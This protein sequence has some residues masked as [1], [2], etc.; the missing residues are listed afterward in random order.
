M[1][2]D[3]RLRVGSFYPPG[4]PFGFG[5]IVFGVG[6]ITGPIIGA[7]FMESINLNGFFVFLII[8]N[9]L[10]ATFGIYRSRVRETVDNPESSFTPLPQ[11]ITP[12]GLELDPS[13]PETLDNPTVAEEKP[14]N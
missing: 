1:S 11:T 5:E 9:L 10:I 14:A 3:W 8:T 2:P 7:I 6:A 4:T 13:T 12:V